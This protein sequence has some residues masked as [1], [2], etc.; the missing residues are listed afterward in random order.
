[1]FPLPLMKQ[2]QPCF[3]NIMLTLCQTVY[4]VAT[5]RYIYCSIVFTSIGLHQ[6][7]YKSLVFPILFFPPVRLCTRYQQ[8]FLLSI[9]FLLLCLH[10]TPDLKGF[11]AEPIFDDW[12]GRW[13]YKWRFLLLQC[14]SS[15]GLYQQARYFCLHP[16]VKNQDMSVFI[17]TILDCLAD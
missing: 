12:V 14:I 15:R 7:V 5:S 16:M 1:M 10:Q 2:A 11:K 13:A 8:I 6:T 9:V 17:F 4:K 3:F